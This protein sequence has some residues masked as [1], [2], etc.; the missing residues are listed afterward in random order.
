MRDQVGFSAQSFTFR[1]DNCVSPKNQLEFSMPFLTLRTGAQAILRAPE[2]GAGGATPADAANADTAA[3]N[4]E[5]PSTEMVGGTTGADLT[6]HVDSRQQA[7]AQAKKLLSNP[8]VRRA[9]MDPAMVRDQGY[10]ELVDGI[11]NSPLYRTFAR[12]VRASLTEQVD[13]TIADSETSGTLITRE[14]LKEPHVYKFTEKAYDLLQETAREA[15]VIGFHGGPKEVELKILPA[16]SPNAY[17]YGLSHEQPRVHVMSALLDVFFN[18][19]TGDWISPESK[20]LAKSV[21][22]HELW[23]IKDNPA[24][25]RTWMGILVAASGLTENHGDGPRFSASQ[26][27]GMIMAGKKLIKESEARTDGRSTCGASSLHSLIVNDKDAAWAKQK[28]KQLGITKEQATELLIKSLNVDFDKPFI[29]RDEAG[30]PTRFG[31]LQGIFAD[32]YQLTRAGEIAADRGTFLI[33]GTNKWTALMDM[34]LGTAN[35]FD[36]FARTNQDKKDFVETV[37]AKGYKS[38]TATQARSRAERAREWSMPAEFDK[39]ECVTHPPTLTRVELGEQYMDRFKNP[40]GY[41]NL[42]KRIDGLSDPAAKAIEAIRAL[43]KR[44]HDELTHFVDPMGFD[45]ADATARVAHSLLYAPSKEEWSKAM[46]G[47]MA[48]FDSIVS[49]EMLAASSGAGSDAF[50]AMLDRI[51]IDEEDMIIESWHSVPMEDLTEHLIRRLEGIQEKLG[52]EA[53]AHLGE[54][55]ERLWDLHRDQIEKA[56]E[57]FSPSDNSAE[58]HLADLLS[59]LNRAEKAEP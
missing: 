59:V 57:V 31:M 22:A 30:K 46:A 56:E 24:E 11:R 44:K 52:P 42:L 29:E 4:G 8:D 50:D 55:I 17:V 25:W 47:A 5:R 13:Q 39:L 19:E 16:L 20:E 3:Q 37:V 23:H 32:S 7:A 28:A 21:I 48:E 18:N 49:D 33:Q 51:D 15:G 34:L 9:L 40:D 14:N 10:R 1:N 54:R 26:K 12:D 41:A 53:G 2:T 36:R 58:R 35:D 6:A 45:R 43:H 27:R 38:W